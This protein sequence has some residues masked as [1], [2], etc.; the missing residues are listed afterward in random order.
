MK[1][2]WLLPSDRSGG[3]SPVA[4]SCCRQA[5]QAGYETTMLLLTQP[6]WISSDEFQVSSL[7]LAG[8]ATEAPKILLQWFKN[9]PQDIIFFNSCEEFEPIIPHLPPSIKCVYVVHDTASPYWSK[10]LEEENNLEAIV[11][12][13]ETVASKFRHRLKQANKLSVIYNG[14]TF[15]EIQNR[16]LSRK[17]DLIYLGGENPIKGAFD[18]INLWKYLIKLGFKGKL[19]WFGNITPKFINRIKQLPN[20]D[21]IEIYGF[22][23]R[24]VI[25]ST[26]ASTK[27]ILMLSRVEP[28]GMATIEAMGMGCLPIAWDVE[29]GTKEIVTA[30]QTGLFA[31]LGNIKTLAK[32]VLFAVENYQTFSHRVIERARSSFDEAVM[33]KNYESLVNSLSEEKSIVR[34]KNGEEPIDFQVPVRR[35]Q[36]LPGGMRSLIREFIGK[37]PA[38]GYL[39]RDMRG[40]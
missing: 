40:W 24:D 27:V 10:A 9:N 14:C 12:V 11:A 18:V 15:P 35:F 21:Q 39:L 29:T 37:S 3:I 23:S 16:N 19:H 30:N 22:V 25:F 17:D 1:L 7:N 4:L 34:S 33:W 20:S 31:P 28:F 36:L 13:S 26:A 5:A 32:Q 2:C 38:L 6:T 8:S